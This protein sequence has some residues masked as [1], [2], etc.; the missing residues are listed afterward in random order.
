M[1]CEANVKDGMLM[2]KAVCKRGAAASAETAVMMIMSTT[3]VI[4][5]ARRCITDSGDSACITVTSQEYP[6]EEGAE[7]AVVLRLNGIPAVTW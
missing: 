7:Y 5:N 4:V 6:Q 2:T 1:L 3:Y